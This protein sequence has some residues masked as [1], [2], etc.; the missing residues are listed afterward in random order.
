MVW[1]DNDPKIKDDIVVSC[2]GQ[3]LRTFNS[4]SNDYAHTAATEFIKELQA[5]DKR[6]EE[7]KNVDD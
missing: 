1:T 7:K 3:V 2:G 4:L 6:R 5:D